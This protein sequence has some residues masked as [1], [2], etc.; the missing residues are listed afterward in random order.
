[1]LHQGPVGLGFLAAAS[2]VGAML[3]LVIINRLRHQ[4]SG[5]WLLTVGTVGMSICLLAFALSSVYP[6]SWIM[7]LLAG[8]GQ[9]C[10]GIMQSSI[11]LLAASDEMRSRAM[12][13][14]VL[15]IG[16]DPLGKLQTGYLAEVYG[17]QL[18][19]AVQAAFAAAALIAI[20]VALPGLRRPL[21]VRPAEQPAAVGA[22]D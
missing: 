21:H 14:L 1:V 11:I 19:V 4:V 5:G 20:A 2:G 18:T 17:A 12:G 3:G 8:I 7:L 15:A 22:D 6:F 10:F 16:S 9:A 13:T